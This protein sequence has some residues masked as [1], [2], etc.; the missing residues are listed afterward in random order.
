V[1]LNKEDILNMSIPQFHAIMT[2]VDIEPEETLYPSSGRMTTGIRLKFILE[3]DKKNKYDVYQAFIKNKNNK[4]ISG[5]LFLQTDNGTI[6]P[7]GTLGILMYYYGVY[8]LGEFIN[9]KIEVQKDKL[10]TWTILGCERIAL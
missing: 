9:K 7:N 2:V 10:H 3:D 5:T 6:S 1:K 8:T 4:V